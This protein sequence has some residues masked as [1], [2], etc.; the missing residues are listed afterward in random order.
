MRASSSSL[1]RPSLKFSSS[2]QAAAETGMRKILELHSKQELAKLCDELGLPD[3]GMQKEQII[4]SIFSEELNNVDDY[5]HVL[6]LMWEG[7][8]PRLCALFL[9]IQ[10]V[11]QS[12]SMYFFYTHLSTSGCLYAINDRD[13]DWISKCWARTGIEELFNGPKTSCSAKV[14]WSIQAWYSN[15]CW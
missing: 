11:M 14:A 6:S 7:R 1:S 9:L 2:A 8:S 13:R 10:F 3:E 4:N 15:T 5:K 12:V